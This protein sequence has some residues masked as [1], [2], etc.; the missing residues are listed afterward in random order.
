MR[1][2]VFTAVNDFPKKSSLERG[3]V[4]TGEAKDL[5]YYVVAGCRVMRENNGLGTL[6]RAQGGDRL[7]MRE[8]MLPNRGPKNGCKASVPRVASPTCTITRLWLGMTRMR[9]PAKPSAKNESLGTARLPMRPPTI[10]VKKNGSGYIFKFVTATFCVH[11]YV[12]FAR[13]ETIEGF[14]QIFRHA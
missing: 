6:K 9:C 12:C 13:T 1:S 3:S 7:E 8:E 10:R 4:T 5:G 11:S 2:R 14:T